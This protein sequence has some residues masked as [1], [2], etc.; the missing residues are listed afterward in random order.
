MGMFGKKTPLDKL[1]L[2]KLHPIVKKQERAMKQT[3]NQMKRL[4]TEQKRA[5]EHARGAT[6][7]E[8]DR[9]RAKFKGNRQQLQLLGK[10]HKR[11]SM[12]YGIVNQVYTLKKMQTR[13]LTTV[14]IAKELEKKV[15]LKSEMIEK[16]MMEHDLKDDAALAGWEA[17]FEAMDDAAVDQFEYQGE[18]HKDPEFDTVVDLLESN[19]STSYEQAM[20]QQRDAES[21]PNTE[22]LPF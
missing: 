4:E 5:I 21:G 18:G 19:P 10:E 20:Q 7:S 17:A 14:S 16:I 6:E 8:K 9:L 12:V 1:P 2:E 22:R 13:G 15:G 3:E 11:M